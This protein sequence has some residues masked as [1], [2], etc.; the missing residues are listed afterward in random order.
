MLFLGTNVR[1]R[2]DLVKSRL[3]KISAICWTQGDIPV[4]DNI[5]AGSCQS[6]HA[7]YCNQFLWLINEIKKYTN[8]ITV[9]HCRRKSTRVTKFL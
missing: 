9:C 8:V 5:T 6:T 7:T 4:C 2:L 1:C 3:T